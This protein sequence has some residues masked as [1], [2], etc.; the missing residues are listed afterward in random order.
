VLGTGGHTEG[1]VSYV[2]EQDG[3]RAVFV[4]D[5]TASA[6]KVLTLHDMEAPYVGGRS[7]GDQIGALQGL[8]QWLPEILLPSHGEPAREPAAAIEQ[9]IAD[10]AAI[11]DEYNWFDYSVPQS[12]TGPTQVSPHVWHM[13]T[14]AGG[15]GFVLLSGE[16]SAFLWDANETDVPYIERILKNSGVGKVDAIAISHYHDDHT[17]GI[18]TLRRMYGAPVWAM[19][20]MVDVLEN[21]MAYNLPCL[22]PE[23]VKVDR[24]LRDG[25]KVNW[26]GIPM[27]FFYLPGQTEYHEGLLVE[28]DGKRLLFTGDNLA[29]PVPGR[30]LLGHYVARNFQKLDGGHW[31]SARKIIELKPD[32]LV[33]NHYDPI[34]ATPEL[35]RSY[36]ASTEQMKTV[37][38][39]ILDQPDPMFGVDN[40]WLS[41]YPYQVEAKPGETVEVEVRYRNWHNRVSTVSTQFRAPEGWEFAPAS[42]EIRAQAK[43]TG[44]G[45][46]RFRVPAGASRN[47]RYVITLETSRDGRRLGEIT[48]MLVNVLPMRAH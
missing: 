2:L 25:E 36:L 1:S 35:L 28:I 39:R 27:Q 8:H 29:K 17:G 10:V 19:D 30:P 14:S 41:V 13:T 20:H 16:G 26:H 37:L 9:L 5:L 42:L 7:L 15:T 33:P 21:P 46:A 22:W 43:G 48:E 12:V 34:P 4:G 11:R 23:P 40:N 6:G 32:L 45:R 3:R 18:N 47:R 24:I 31:Y 44:T 38:A